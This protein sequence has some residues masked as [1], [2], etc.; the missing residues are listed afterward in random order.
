MMVAAVWGGWV[1]DWRVGKCVLG[2]VLGSDVWWGSSRRGGS[3]VVI[4]WGSC[5]V[6][7]GWVRGV[8]VLESVVCLILTVGVCVVSVMM[9][10][11][12]FV[13]AASLIGWWVVTAMSV[14]SS[15]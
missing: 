1:G 4:G 13:G 14:K 2:V 15:G 3:S 10:V 6:V 12:L 5:G 9:L 7:R 8:T 11:L